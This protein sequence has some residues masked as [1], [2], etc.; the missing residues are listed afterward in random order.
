ML[1]S[2]VD[3][4]QMAEGGTL[5]STSKSDRHILEDVLEDFGV[6]KQSSSA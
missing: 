2:S 6:L 5:K 3:A 1:T 4:C